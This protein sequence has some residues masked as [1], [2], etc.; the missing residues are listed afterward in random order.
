MGMYGHFKVRSGA[1]AL[2][3]VTDDEVEAVCSETARVGPNADAVAWLTVRLLKEV[4]D[5]LRGEVC[6]PASA[7]PEVVEAEVAEVGE[8]PVM[9]QIMRRRGRKG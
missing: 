3:P 9:E 4:R 2:Q 5:L 1:G 8:S 6:Q 7:G